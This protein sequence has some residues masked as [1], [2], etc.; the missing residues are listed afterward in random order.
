MMKHGTHCYFRTHW[1]PLLK[2]AGSVLDLL[3]TC[4]FRS[5]EDFLLILYHLFPV[6]DLRKRLVGLPPSP[7]PPSLIT[8]KK[9]KN[10]KGQ[11]FLGPPIIFK[12]PVHKGSLMQG[13]LA[14][15]CCSHKLVLLFTHRDTCVF[16]CEQHMILWLQHVNVI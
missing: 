5:P 3:C 4:T 10:L 1:S 13:H 9:F 15:I 2:L 7:P 8:G 11:Y 6:S 14:M 16:I 12:L